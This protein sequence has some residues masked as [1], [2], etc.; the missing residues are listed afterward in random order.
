M[1]MYYD[2]SSSPTTNA[3]AG[4]QSTSSHAKL[5]TAANQTVCMVKGVYVGARSGTA[6][7]GQLKV[8]TAATA[9]SSSGSSF[10]ANKRQSN[11]A[12]ASTSAMTASTCS[13]TATLRTSIGFAQTGGMGGWVA[14]EPDAAIQLLP[15]GGAT[16]NAE[17]TSTANA[18]SIALDLTIEFSE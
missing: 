7:G 4:S 9:Q 11:F 18:S 10:V 8:I 2:V 14:I 3:S 13:Q 15:N 6:G 12:T 1:P 5:L 16:G 17:F